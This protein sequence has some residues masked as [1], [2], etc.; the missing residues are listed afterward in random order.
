MTETSAHDLLSR[1]RSERWIYARS[2]TVQ[3]TVPDRVAPAPR[4]GIAPTD[5]GGGGVLA[6]VLVAKLP[7]GLTMTADEFFVG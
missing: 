1:A 2:V 3:T 4:I 7:S 5:L 6:P